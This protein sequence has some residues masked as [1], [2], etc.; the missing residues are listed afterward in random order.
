MVVAAC[1]PCDDRHMNA[2]RAFRLLLV[3]VGVAFGAFSLSIALGE[4]SY[5]F[6][7]GSTARSAA[8]LIAGWS[9]LGVG[10]VAWER[11]PT[12]SFGALL[13]ASS[14]GWFLLEWN[15][16]GA[17]SAL[18]FT[19]GLVVFLAASP[20]VAHAVVSYPDGR[21]RGLL[22]RIAV[23]A[24]YAG[25]IVLLGLLPTL[26]FDPRAEGCTECPRNLLLVT[27]DRNLYNT[28]NRIGVRAGLGW[29]IL[30]VVLIAWRLTRLTPAR[31]WLA[32][33]VLICGCT[34]VALVAADF[35]HAFGR[36]FM[37]NDRIDRQLWLW[38]ALALVALSLS[39]VW[40]WLRAWQAKAEVAR[41]VIE[42]VESPAPGGLRDLLA[43]TLG[44][45]SLELAYPLQEGK[46]VNARGQPVTLSGQITPLI[47]G[48]REVARLGHRP[49]LLDNAEQV[50]VVAATARLALENERLH[51]ETQAQL[52]ELLASRARVIAAGD[53]E[54][55]RL[56]QNLHDGAQQRLV[57]LSLSLRLARSGSGSPDHSLDGGI[58]QA[59]SELG[60]ALAELRELAHGI[61]PAV[62]ADE[63]LAAALEALSEEAPLRIT[64][65]PD[66]RLE[67]TV[68]SAVYFI[69]SEALKRSPANELEIAARC[70]NGALVIDLAGSGPLGDVTDFEDRIQ[71]LD[72]TLTIVRSQ[73]ARV[74]IHAEI[75]CES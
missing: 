3:P 74:T 12:S 16:P 33:P 18:V 20:L 28:L 51:A 6:A 17:G 11:R 63:G 56:E 15:N 25:A 75:P 73:N 71:A 26:V 29:S 8:E 37:S 67:P 35:I 24:A 9:L 38:Q 58:D 49:G 66:H 42:L 27:G 39:V 22:D 4:S 23:A 59:E 30:L 69:V 48:G 53:A 45:P 14:F 52:D 47:R 19:T 50:E 65:L 5:S 72:G 62:L 55:R 10:L 41:L 60:A 32:A 68:E 57:A 54:R 21:L 1:N 64:E 44:D 31:R 2:S 46:L 70:S 34:Y 43:R 7:G 61:F 40:P 13:C 36:G